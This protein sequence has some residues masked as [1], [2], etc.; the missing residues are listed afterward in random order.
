M[1]SITA[2][3][4]CLAL[5]SLLATPA[6][7]GM[8]MGGKGNHHKHEP[9]LLVAWKSMYGVDGPFV[10]DANKVRGVQGDELPW[11]IEKSAK[12]FL[13]T[14]GRLVIDVHGLVFKVDPSVPPEIQGTNDETAF[15]GLVSC[16][17]EE[18]DSVVEKNVV[19]AGFP[20]NTHGDSFINAQVELPNPCVAPVVMVLAGSEDKWFAITG[21]E[22]EEGD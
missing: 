13:T 7:A 8:G 17:T 19:T 3:G 12:G 20:A 1:R 16:L 14:S 9:R 21:F 5:A 4:L 22:A 11:E 2:T 10:G 15:R 6:S 18:G